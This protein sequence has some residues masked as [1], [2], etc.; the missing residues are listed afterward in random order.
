MRRF[1]PANDGQAG[2]GAFTFVELLMAIAIAAA[3]VATA[4]IAYQ[5]MAQS[6]SR[7][8]TYG[9]VELP[10]GV[11]DNFYGQD[12]AYVETYF[13]PNYGRIAMAEGLRDS[14]YDDL[15]HANAVFCLVREGLST[16]RPTEIPI[17]ATYDARRL[18]TPEAFRVF[19][20]AAIPESADVFSS[21]RGAGDERNLS[22]FIL[23]PSED[24]EVL[25]VR[26][27][28]ESDFVESSNPAGTYASVR[29]YQGDVCTDYYDVFYPAAAQTTDFFP[30]V[31]HFERQARMA[32]VEGAND[33][34]KLAA[35]RPFY[36]VW[37]PDPSVP[38][39]ES[40]E[41]ASLPSADPRNAYSEMTG[42][43]S[44]FMVVPMFPAL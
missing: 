10:D 13:A 17:A 36:F 8:G 9:S 20:A 5:A 26:A 21:Y 23:M 37:W 22:I 35:N 19:L 43:T 4:V 32:T 29:R 39:L 16:I 40:T 42:R 28:Y 34:L 44:L 7:L 41:A 2:E 27:V 24:P 15:S 18:D 12:S 3:V 1:H 31:A 38:A 30:V 6:G 11:L 33:L 14:L 25:T